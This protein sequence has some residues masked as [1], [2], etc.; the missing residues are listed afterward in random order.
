MRGTGHGRIAAP[1]GGWWVV[2][3]FG[4]GASSEQARAPELHPPRVE[5]PAPPRAPAEG[6]APASPVSAEPGPGATPPGTTACRSVAHI[7]DSTSTGTM[8]PVYIHDPERRLDRQ[9][10]RV[11]VEQL[12]L[13]NFG[14][15]SLVEHRK[16]PNG[17]M[18]A[19]DLRARGFAGCWVI[20]LGT[21]D[22]ANAAKD[23]TVPPVTRIER[24]M[25]VIGEEPVLWIDAAT[26]TQEGYWAEANMRR[27]NE[28][29]AATLARFP[30]ARIYRWSAE[31]LDEWFVSDGIHYTSA[32]YAARAERVADALA[33]AFPAGP[34]R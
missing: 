22:A 11:G 2:A 13:E 30:N 7:G 32:G 29:L 25:A 5:A 4:C 12:V 19:S 3:L 23:P 27:W 15:R 31:V 34:A 28:D 21:N 8:N 26:R 18:V 17:V 33:A 20:G 1:R 16:S 14:G 24:M 10:A 9:Y 6:P